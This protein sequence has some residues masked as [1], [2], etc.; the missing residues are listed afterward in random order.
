MDFPMDK[1]QMI[2]LFLPPFIISLSF[3]EYAHAWV[4]E[5]FGDSTARYMGRMTVDPMAHISWFGTIIFPALSILMG[6]HLLFGWANP[7]PVDSRNFKKPFQHMALV[8]AAGPASNI[9]LAIV[10][11]FIMSMLKSYVPGSIFQAMEVQGMMGSGLKMLD[12]AVQ[13]NLFLAFFNLLP[14]PPLDGAR[15]IQGLV[16]P[17]TALKIDEYSNQAQ[18]LLIILLFTGVLRYLALPVTILYALIYQVFNII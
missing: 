12:M 2:L 14:L 6:S 4:A 18:I 8:A 1:V 3:H 16:K 13:L 11:A 5:R 15:I 9:L 7:V 17:A 10:F